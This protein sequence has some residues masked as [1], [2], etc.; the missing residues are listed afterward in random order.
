[1]NESPSRE[2]TFGVSFMKLQKICLIR[3]KKNASIWFRVNIKWNLTDKQE[4]Q[5]SSRSLLAPNAKYDARTLFTK[6]LAKT[7][8]Y[9]GCATHLRQWI[10]YSNRK[11]ADDLTSKKKKRIL[12]S[13]YLHKRQANEIKL[14]ASS[15]TRERKRNTSQTNTEDYQIFIFR[16]TIDNWICVGKRAAAFLLP[17]YYITFI[18]PHGK[19]NHRHQC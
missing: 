3:L 4:E 9:L 14:L 16:R 7:S 15:G 11:S 17:T 2:K 13:R 19:P 18:L 5:N 1:M 12:P 10:S 8:T 6:E